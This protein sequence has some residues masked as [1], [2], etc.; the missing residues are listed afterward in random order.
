MSQFGLDPLYLTPGPS[1]ELGPNSCCVSGAVCCPILL[2]ALCSVEPP[3][4]LG[5]LLLTQPPS[6]PTLGASQTEMFPQPHLL[7]LSL[8]L[9]FQTRSYW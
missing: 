8:L 3:L 6:L 7:S 9:P 5:P 2:L 4:P 1:L